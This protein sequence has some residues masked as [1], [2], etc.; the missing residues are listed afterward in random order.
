[1]N[2]DRAPTDLQ[3]RQSTRRAGF[4][5]IELLVVIAIIALLI[6]I[7]LPT[8]AHARQSAK[9]TVC[10]SNIRSQG[11]VVHAYAGDHKDALPP[12]AVNWNQQQPDGTYRQSIW[13]LTRILAMYEGNP[14]LNEEEHFSPTGHYRC[15][16]I[17]KNDELAYTNHFAIFH[18]SANQWLFNLANIDEETGDHDF[19]AD[20]MDGWTSLASVWRRIDMVASPTDVTM[21]HD[22][23]SFYFISENH[24]HGREALGRAWQIVP[25]TPV[26]NRGSH[27]AMA[28]FPVFFVDGHSV[29]L[30]VSAT[31][32]DDEHTTFTGPEGGVPQ[33][34]SRTEA[35][36]LIWFLPRN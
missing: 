12:R 35:L 21:L 31:Y 2:R 30:P 34:L 3:T 7:L 9:L 23:M 13:F 15:P 5:L 25:G 19:Y 32:W 11:Q 20:A 29:P 18:T 22:A 33:D 26:D 6:S 8:L 14:M 17:P 28:R 36:R 24:R 4:T 27:A 1:M 16:N 10:T